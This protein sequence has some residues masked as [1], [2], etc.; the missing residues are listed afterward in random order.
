VL[1]ISQNGFKKNISKIPIAPNQKLNEKANT[2]TNFSYS[3][4]KISHK[5]RSLFSSK[6][7]FKLK[8]GKNGIL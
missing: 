1:K 4:Q 7:T 8:K 6:K 5:Q 2:N 3:L